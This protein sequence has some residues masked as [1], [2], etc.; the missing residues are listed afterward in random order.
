MRCGRGTGW[1]RPFPSEDISYHR[2]NIKVILK[3]HA[4]QS[5]GDRLRR[6]GGTVTDAAE[7]TVIFFLRRPPLQKHA[8]N[9]SSEFKELRGYGDAFLPMVPETAVGWGTLGYFNLGDEDV[10]CTYAPVTR[11]PPD[12]FA[13]DKNFLCAP[14]LGYIITGTKAS[15]PPALKPL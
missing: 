1:T 8:L 11:Y 5:C 12:V 7:S 15:S 2:I 9:S 13:Y 6:I 3:F 4:L 10:L 14:Q